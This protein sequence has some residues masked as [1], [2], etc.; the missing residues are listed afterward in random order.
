MD[1]YFMTKLK[2]VE[3]TMNKRNMAKLT[4]ELIFYG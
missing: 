3:L 1:Q 2:M 4:N